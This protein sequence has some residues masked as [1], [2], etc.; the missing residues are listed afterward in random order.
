MSPT[1]GPTFEARVRARLAILLNDVGAQVVVDNIKAVAKEGVLI[2][3]FH[4]EGAWSC[5]AGFT[6]PFHVRVSLDQS[7]T[8]LRDMVSK[9]WNRAHLPPPVAPRPASASQMGAD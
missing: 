4:L 5:P 7:V 1:T 2:V 8:A 9:N 3:D 6:F